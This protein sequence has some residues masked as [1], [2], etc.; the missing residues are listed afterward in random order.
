MDNNAPNVDIASVA[1][2]IRSATKRMSHLIASAH[3][4][5]LSVNSSV[6]DGTWFTAQLPIGKDATRG[7]RP[8]ASGG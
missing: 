2:R 1:G 6:E 8:V 5:A 4:G 3:G 7:E